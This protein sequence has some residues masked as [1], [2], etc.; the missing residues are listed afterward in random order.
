[1]GDPG[2]RH[3]PQRASIRL[4]PKARAAGRLRFTSSEEPR[5]SR[6]TSRRGDGVRE[7][8][9]R[10]T[11]SC[12]P[13]TVLMLFPADHSRVRKKYAALTGIAEHT[14]HEVAVEPI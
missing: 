4:E 2:R 1:M 7:A 9:A 8:R 10:P 6:R 13:T 14:Q 11:R 12:R 3:P 5:T